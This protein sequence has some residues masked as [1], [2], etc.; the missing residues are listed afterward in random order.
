MD[1]QT[2]TPVTDETVVAAPEVVEET[3]TV[4]AAPVEEATE[5]VTA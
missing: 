3:E 2:T 1:T 5:E 4:E